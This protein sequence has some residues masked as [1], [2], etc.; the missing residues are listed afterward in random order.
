MEA[1]HG[2]DDYGGDRLPYDLL[3][4][5]LGRL[6]CGDLAL[7]RRVC[8]AWRDAVDDGALLLPH[9]HRI[10][11]P[12]AFPGIFT[13]NY[14]I[15]ENSSFFTPSVGGGKTSERR[16][17]G[18]RYPLFRH[19]WATVMDHCNGLL[20][21]TNSDS[22]FFY[23]CN[24]AT[25]RC[26]RLP[27]LPAAVSSEYRKL[28]IFLAFDPALSRHHKVFLFPN[29]L[30][31]LRLTRME[32]LDL[33]DYYDLFFSKRDYY[34][35]LEQE[36]QSEE[37]E[38][39]EPQQTEQPQDQQDDLEPPVDDHKREVLSLLV[40]SSQ[41]DKWE[42]REFVPARHA[43]EHLCD[44]F[45]GTCKKIWKSAEY[46]RG[47]LYVHCRGNVLMILRD[48]Q[49]TYDII[50]LPGNP[51]DD[52]CDGEYCGCMYQLPTRSV[53]A[54]YEK[55]IRYV[56]LNTFQLQVWTLTE[57]ADEEPSWRMTHDANL[58]PYHIQVG[59]SLLSIRLM[60]PC[61]VVESRRGRISLFDYGSYTYKALFDEEDGK[62][63]EDDDDVN[64]GCGGGGD[65]DDDGCGGDDDDDNDDDDDDC[66]GGGDE[67]EEEDSE[68]SWKSDEDNF[69]DMDK[70]T[71]YLAPLYSY[72]SIRIIGL[73]TY[74][75]V[76]LL[77]IKGCVVAYH[78]SIS[79]MQYLVH[80]PI[81]NFFPANRVCRAF[82]YRP[83][84]VDMLS[85]RK[86]TI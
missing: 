48:S 46:W 51:C 76:L 81:E 2:G 23:V 60:V 56:E 45:T 10:F 72:E 24:P 73:H 59:H 13:S 21:L 47:S 36:Q 44:V 43:P 16:G 17:G 35:L 15:D 4:D 18:F 30:P 8:R 82:P 41:I 62:S 61:E 32:I 33:P 64:D 49:A 1:S 68:C 19:D 5:I 25:V 38:K 7:S 65:D 78:L 42:S 58:S 79:R 55:G 85:S 34:D 53:L 29:S 11:P 27:P 22:S 52:E 70:S 75:D 71:I 28:G 67:K 83:C 39:E 9:F 86:M 74:K 20:L 63:E 40:F 54:S 57:R 12:R 14:G 80:Q 31:H 84:Y 69:I 77:H 50:P 3:V 6:Q 26:A 66:G 37:E